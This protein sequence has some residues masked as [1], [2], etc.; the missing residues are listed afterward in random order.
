MLERI[1]RR[2]GRARL[3]LAACILVP[4]VA[5][6]GAARAD[7]SPLLAARAVASTTVE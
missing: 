1:G 5:A 3:V 7:V 4:A 6:A 2:S